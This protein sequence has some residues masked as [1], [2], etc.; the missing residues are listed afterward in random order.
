MIQT[1]LLRGKETY[2]QINILGDDGVPVDYHITYW[3]S[4]VVDGVLLQQDLLDEVDRT[5]PLDRQKF[6]LDKT[7]EIIQAD[8]E[9]DNFE[10]IMGFFKKVIN[11]FKQMNFS[12]Y[13]TDDFKKYQSELEQL[14]EG[15][16]LVAN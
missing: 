8:Y 12:G 15:K 14:L 11:L 13:G 7:M 9:F 5:C 2:E 6:M 1:G 4:E 3:K 16:Q 10:E